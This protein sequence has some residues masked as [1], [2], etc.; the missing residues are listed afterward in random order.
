MLERW[1]KPRID[2]PDPAVRG[3]ALLQLDADDPA[4]VAAVRGDE[5]AGVRAK[6]LGK[7]A[8]WSLLEERAREDHAVREAARSRIEALLAAAEEIDVAARH[9]FVAS[10]NDPKL[11]RAAALR[12]PDV[13]VRRLA[14]ARHAES[15]A[16]HAALLAEVVATDSDP[17]LRRETLT[18]IDDVE[19]LEKAAVEWRK[20]DKHFYKEMRDRIRSLRLAREHAD[21]GAKLAADIATLAEQPVA[22]N[23]EPMHVAV[24][25]LQNWRQEWD[26]L[27]AAG[28][29][30]LPDVSEALGR[31]ESRIERAREIMTERAALL[32]ALGTQDFDGDEPDWRARWDALRDHTQAQ[33]AQFE[34]RLAARA[35]RRTEHGEACSAID[36]ARRFLDEQEAREEVS[37][38]RLAHVEK[39]WASL[40]PPAGEDGEA[41]I[42]R[43]EALRA[44][45]AAQIEEKQAAQAKAAAAAEPLLDKLEQA[46][47]EGQLGPATSAHDKLHHQLGQKDVLPAPVAER[48]RKGLATL[49]PKLRELKEARGWST[50][51]ARESLTKD[52][53]TLA[54]AAPALAPAEISRKV[55][56]LRAQWQELDKGVGPAPQE[57]WAAFDG[58]CKRAY[59]PAKEQYDAAAAKRRALV[60]D[61]DAAAKALDPQNADWDR[62]VK[63]VRDSRKAWREAGHMEHRKFVKLRKRFDAAIKPLDAALDE[64]RERD[65]RRRQLA[66]AA[67]ERCVARE[68]LEAQIEMAKQVQREWRPTVRGRRKDEQAL[69]DTLRKLCDDIFGRRDARFSDR[70]AAEDAAAAAKN[71][72]CD[73]IEALLT[74]DEGETDEAAVNQAKGQYRTLRAAWRDAGDVGPKKKGAAQK[75][76]RAVCDRF[77]ARLRERERAGATR[78]HEALIERLALLDRHREALAAGGDAA[79]TREQW[80]ALPPVRGALGKKLD[81]AFEADAAG[82]DAAALEA[83]QTLCLQA[84]LA[85][86]VPSPEAF[87]AA[88]MAMKIARLESALAGGGERTAVADLVEAWV[89]LPSVGEAE[90]APLR[91][92]F[93]TALRALA[94]G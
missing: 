73:Q 14:L 44:R 18:H 88:R 33:T 40:I 12:C 67:L 42:A 71:A 78:T 50:R 38:H 43:Y 65:A 83:K 89:A 90:A 4:F 72:V 22:A 37:E 45:I 3:D 27:A 54:E 25:L 39:T 30:P 31:A 79:A 23:G 55:K 24:A 70:R 74:G 60:D 26:A 19:A 61:L 21:Q 92:R 5:D 94:A 59:A 84:E 8:D 11:L 53:E 20:S 85:A 81:A 9:A 86:D 76:Y 32:D 64:E 62:L 13:A 16:E 91:E 58:A 77:E 56:A 6:L 63:L 52:A 7:T 28:D 1:R 80:S 66:I 34:S 68:P 48:L 2:H 46:L 82:A 93:V 47:A 17:A 87:A 49:A 75:R 69:W 15:G 29:A 36:T 57:V 41:L 51:Q 35:R 10:L